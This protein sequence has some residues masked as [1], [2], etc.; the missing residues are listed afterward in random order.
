[1]RLRTANLTDVMQ[2]SL[3]IPYETFSFSKVVSD[4][5]LDCRTRTRTT[6]T[7]TTYFVVEEFEFGNLY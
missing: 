4:G 5:C 3:G 2:C 6:T 7:T 1:M